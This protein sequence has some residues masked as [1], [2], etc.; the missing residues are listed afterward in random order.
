MI[1]NFK[2]ITMLHKQ[3]IRYT[4]FFFALAYLIT[5]TSCNKEDSGGKPSITQLRAI[6]PAPNDSVLHKAGPGQTVVIQGANLATTAQIYF[7]G[8]PAPFNS[9]LFSDENVV[10]TIPADM[11]FASLDQTKL[12]TVRLVT[13]FGEVTFSFPIEPPPP[14]ITSMTNEMAL[15]GERVTLFGNNFFFIEKVIFPGN[16]EATTNIVTN[17]SGTTLEVTVPAGVTQGGALKVV[18]RYGTGTSLL[19]FNDLVTGVLLNFDNVNSINNWAGVGISS[20]STDFPG[21][22]GTYAR[23]TYTGVAAGDGAWWQGGRSI[24]VEQTFQWVPLANLNEPLDNFAMKFEVNTKVPMK[25]LTLLLDK[26]YSFNFQ[27]RFEPWKATGGEYKSE[28]WKT[29]VVPLSNFKKDA[30]NGAAPANLKALLGDDGNGGMNVFVVNSSNAAVAS[31]DMAIDNFRVVR[32]K[33]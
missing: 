10:V 31:F 29:F 13:K 1:F 32:I 11:P 8:Y 26:D 2:N 28:G 24:N 33:N 18:N 27:G 12:N 30:G 19:L 25:G 20:S 14:I 22:R 4:F 21:N 6:T 7:N 3:Y 23:M 9:A 15:P 17:A 5:Q 16:I